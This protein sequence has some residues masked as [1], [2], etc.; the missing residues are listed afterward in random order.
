MEVTADCLPESFDVVS[1]VGPTSEIRQVELDLIPSLV[2]T[3]GHGTDER[4]HSGGALV[5]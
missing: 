4:L 2:Q 5:V 1:S 3:H